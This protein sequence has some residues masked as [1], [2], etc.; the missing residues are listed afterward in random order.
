VYT[1]LDLS[2]TFCFIVESGNDDFNSWPRSHM[3]IS[4]LL[5]RQPV[6]MTSFPG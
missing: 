6:Y 4:S 5:G 3:Q 2:L 1:F